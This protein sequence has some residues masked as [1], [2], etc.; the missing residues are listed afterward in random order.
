MTATATRTQTPTVA[1]VGAGFGGLAA[2]IELKRHGIESFTVLERADHVGGVWQAN[3]YPGAACD[4]PSV[5]YQFS[6]AL[7]P[8]WSRRFGTQDEIRRYLHDVAREQGVLDHVRFGA[9]VTAATF[10]EGTG[11]WTVELAGGE[12]LEVDVLLC[13]PG[14]LSRPKVPDL[15][16]RA[17]FAG[18]QFHSAEWDHGVSLEGKR[19]VVVGGG[20]SAVQVVPAIADTAAHVTVV[21]RSPSWIVNKW[22]WTPGRVE[23]ALMR[24][25]RA[26]RLYHNAMWLWFESRYP[27]VKRASR[28]L[29]WAWEQERKAT[30]RRILKDPQKVRACTPD[31]QMGCNRLLLSRA[32]YPTLARPDVDVV[33]AGVDRLTA[34]GVVCSDGTHVAADVV[35]WCTGFTATEYLAPMEITGRGGRT[36]REAWAEGP[37]AYLGLTTPGFPNLFMSYGPNTGSLT[38]TIVYLLERQASYMRQAVEHLGARGGWIDVREDVHAAFNAEVQERLAGTVFTTGCP[39]WYTTDSG[40]VTQVWCGSHVEYGKRVARFDPR[41]YEHHP[42]RDRTPDEP[43]E[44]AA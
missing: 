24:S 27:V 3:Q 14:Q 19:V 36:I 31:Y 18:A 44:V 30:M 42:A 16:G 41:A 4:V 6:F 37:E 9:E 26:Q 5:I 33:G 22:D 17:D 23:R 12:Q 39:G 35:V 29:R 7:K 34:G 11:R 15:P 38:N 40:K 25:P 13:A 28:P 20:A 1:I 32:W 2:A 43:Q 8:D 21:Q 10:D